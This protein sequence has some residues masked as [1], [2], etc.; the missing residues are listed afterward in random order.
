MSC[1]RAPALSGATF[2][3]EI[4]KKTKRREMKTMIKLRNYL[5]KLMRQ[6]IKIEKR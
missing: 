5:I 3:K 1:R 6:V 2:N 4:A